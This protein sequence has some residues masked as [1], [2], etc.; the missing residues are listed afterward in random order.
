MANNR[1]TLTCTQ[2]SD[3]ITQLS[4]KPVADMQQLRNTIAMTPPGTD[5][6]MKVFR[7]GDLKDVTIKIAEQPEDAMAMN[8]VRG[9][10]ARVDK[11]TPDILGLKLTTIT[12]DLATKYELGDVKTGAL[13]TAVAPKSA[14][15][16]AGLRPG[17]VITKVDRQA[18]ANVKETA[19]ALGKGDIAKGVRLNV[20]NRDGS[21]F[22][23]LRNAA[24]E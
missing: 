24:K 12:E 22:L 4:G 20:T 15:A 18:V 16:R 6:V 5:V 23:F 7:D 8:T 19:D 13:V 1:L 3:I 2:P 9:G 10:P 17:D 14:A 11:G 21:R